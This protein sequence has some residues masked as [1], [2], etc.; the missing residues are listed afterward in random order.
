MEITPENPIRILVIDDNTA[1]ADGIRQVLERVQFMV[2]VAYNGTDG[3]HE[4]AEFKPDIV[5]LD[6]VMPDIDG[7]EV[8]RKIKS[9]PDTRSII[10]VLL[11]GLKTSSEDQS[12]GLDEGADGFITRPV[13]TRELL[14]R[15]KSFAR[16][17]Q[18][19][20]LLRLNETR[21]RLLF[22][23]MM[24]G[25]ALHQIILDDDGKPVDYR[26]LEV[27]PAYE[28]ITGL[29]GSAIIGKTIL[30]IFPDTEMFWINMYGAVALTGKE[31]RFE[32]YSGA[33]DKHFD[34]YAFSPGPGLFSTVFSDITERKIVEEKRTQVNQQLEQLNENK[35]KFISIIGHD[36]KSPFNVLIGLSEI[37]ASDETMPVETVRQYCK[38][39]NNSA[40]NIHNLLENLLEWSRLEMGVLK[41][42]TEPVL[43]WEPV[44]EL[45]DLYREAIKLKRIMVIRKVNPTQVVM[46]DKNMVKT[47]L[48]NLLSNAIKFSYELGEITLE[49]VVHESL[50]GIVISDKGAGMNENQLSKLEVPGDLLSTPGTFGEK[51][52][53]I[54]LQIT[55]QLIA[56]NKGT[57]TI[58]SKPGLGTSFTV[59]FPRP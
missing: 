6:I 11:S 57:F 42:E 32:N 23:T 5:L 22:N 28:R 15:L 14:A 7:Y 2:S 25:Y 20:R 8:C 19:E 24:N 36:L 10:V 16:I 30:E 50:S 39:I 35:N 21:Y 18:D 55:R 41:C 1:F 44:N 31:M 46:A 53:G 37:I 13:S 54:G 3:L 4:V 27:N 40:K 48:R 33:L 51:G 49:T 12:D 9:N 26:I 47:I 34:V 43:L 29:D 58:H 17:K 52:S 59:L 45:L 38:T 56:L